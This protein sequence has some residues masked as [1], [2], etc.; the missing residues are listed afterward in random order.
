MNPAEHVFHLLDSYKNQ[1]TPRVA[2]ELATQVENS[3]T[4]H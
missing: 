1:K 2:T 3:K 4:D